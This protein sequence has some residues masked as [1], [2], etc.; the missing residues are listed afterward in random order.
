MP[1]GTSASSVG[2]LPEFD[3]YGT[4]AFTLTLDLD[5]GATKTYAA[6]DFLSLIIDLSGI[7]KP[8]DLSDLVAKTLIIPVVA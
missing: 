3:I 2:V 6:D 7:V 8:L 4:V 1:S 5:A